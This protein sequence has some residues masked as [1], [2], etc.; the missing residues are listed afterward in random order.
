M[1]IIHVLRVTRCTQGCHRQYLRQTY[2]AYVT[3]LKLY[4]GE[5]TPATLFGASDTADVQVAT[6]SYGLGDWY[7]VQG[8]TVKAKAAFERAVAS[9]G[10]PGFGF[11]VS[12]AELKR[13]GKK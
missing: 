10:W 6:L 5:L 2:Y 4:R 13:M 3:R 8:D 9:G 1:Q 7:M 11:I 12:E